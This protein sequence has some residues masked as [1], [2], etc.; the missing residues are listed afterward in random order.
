MN[1]ALAAGTAAPAGARRE[2]GFTLI[3]VLVAL[4]IVTIGMGALLGTLS[5]SADSTSYMRD[6]TFAEWVALNRLEE[7]RLALQRPKKGKSDGEAELAGRKWKWAQ[8]VLETEVKGILRV[9]VSARPLD[10]PGAKDSY[11]TTVSGIIGDALA[12]PRGDAD[13]YGAPLE[14]APGGPGGPQNG[15]Q[16]GNT[17][18]QNTVVTPP[19]EPTPPLAPGAKPPNPTD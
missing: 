5:S 9:D 7:V 14:A 12:L 8:E 15:Q 18:G 17:P 13:L 19:K 4:A 16:P 3:E 11:Y 10:A 1:R 6:K 2:A